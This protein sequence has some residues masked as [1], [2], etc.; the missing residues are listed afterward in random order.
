VIDISTAFV[1]SGLVVWRI[2]SFLGGERGPFGLGTWIR[3]LVGLVPGPDGG[4]EYDDLGEVKLTPPT[5]WDRVNKVLYE[6]AAAMI[7]VRCCSF[8]IAVIVAPFAPPVVAYPFAVLALSTIAIVCESI[9]N[10]E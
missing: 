10:R 9:V 2:A 4:I 6:V 3:K 8:W 5:R 7:C 1:V